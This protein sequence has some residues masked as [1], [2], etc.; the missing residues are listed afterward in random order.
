MVNLAR[1]YEVCMQILQITEPS[2]NE[3]RTMLFRPLDNL[4]PK[5]NTHIVVNRRLP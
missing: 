4:H 2:R 1:V 5:D 3:Q